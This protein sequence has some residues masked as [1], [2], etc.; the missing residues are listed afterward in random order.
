MNGE[1]I[2]SDLNKIFMEKLCDA[3]SENAQQIMNDWGFSESHKKYFGAFAYDC[4]IFGAYW[5]ERELEKS[6]E[7]DADA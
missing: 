5:M 1:K 2:K 7:V 3:A 6:N 4:F